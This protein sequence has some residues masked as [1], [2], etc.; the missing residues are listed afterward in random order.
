[1]FLFVSYNSLAGEISYYG[2]HPNFTPAN[3]IS[4]AKHLTGIGA[5]FHTPLLS[6]AKLE[7]LYWGTNNKFCGSINRFVYYSSY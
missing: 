7:L 5:S 4:F 3:D 2:W 1:M 6:V